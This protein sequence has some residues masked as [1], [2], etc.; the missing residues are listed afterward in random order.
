MKFGRKGFKWFLDKIMMI[1]W[2]MIQELDE[3]IKARFVE[4]FVDRTN[5]KVARSIRTNG[6]DKDIEKFDVGSMGYAFADHHW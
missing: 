1:R 2:R 3:L 4:M 5:P 6:T